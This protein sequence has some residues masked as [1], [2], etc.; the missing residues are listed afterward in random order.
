MK[1]L[2][3]IA[4]R[5]ALSY[6][7]VFDVV[8]ADA[9]GEEILRGLK[10]VAPVVSVQ[11]STLGGPERVSLMLLVSLDA[12]E[13][14]ANGIL[15]NSTYF[16]MHLGNDGVLYH[17]SGHTPGLKFRKTRVRSADEVVRKV[18]AFV[19]EVGRRR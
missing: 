19:E 16:R 17:F 13:T 4:E 8:S 12:R 14:W 18:S 3:A 6:V 15:E 9:W 2:E 11:K 10:R 1:R 5:V 7:P